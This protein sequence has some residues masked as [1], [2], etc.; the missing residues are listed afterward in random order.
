M[1]RQRETCGDW[2]LSSDRW[3]AGFGTSHV[4]KLRALPEHVCT[5]ASG[6]MI[7]GFFNRW[8]NAEREFVSVGTFV[9]S[10]ST[11][12]GEEPGEFVVPVATGS[13]GLFAGFT[14]MQGEGQNAVFTFAN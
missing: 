5:F 1:R 6:T 12:R 2:V 7:G 4:V 14:G 11:V 13:E 8:L 9:V 3:T 10:E